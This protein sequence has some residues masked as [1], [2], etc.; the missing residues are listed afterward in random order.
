MSLANK[1]DKDFIPTPVHRLDRNVSGVMLLALNIQSLRALT[2]LFR[3]RKIIKRYLAVV[4][5]PLEGEGIV[6]VS[7]NKDK[8][9]LKQ[10]LNTQKGRDQ[11]LDIELYV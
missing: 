5:G 1:T 3:D 9:S 6:D 4:K 10:G 11:L 7:L 8:H 2:G